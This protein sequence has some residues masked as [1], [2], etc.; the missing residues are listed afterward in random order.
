MA[1]S[2]QR[3][4]SGCCRQLRMLVVT[5][6]QGPCPF[7]WG[8][9]LPVVWPR[10]HRQLRLQGDWFKGVCGVHPCCSR[11]EGGPGRPC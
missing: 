11:Q 4:G 3:G 10:L 5:G 8:V 6:E 9:W 1:P 2:Q 7:F